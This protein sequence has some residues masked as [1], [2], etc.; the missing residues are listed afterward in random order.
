MLM[1][2]A[3]LEKNVIDPWMNPLGPCLLKGVKILLRLVL[4]FP[5]SILRTK[6]I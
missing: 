1:K 5:A 6:T 3:G 4:K 2:I